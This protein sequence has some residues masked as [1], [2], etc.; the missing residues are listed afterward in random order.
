MFKRALSIIKIAVG[1]AH[2][3]YSRGAKNYAVLLR[4]LGREEEAD[5]ILDS[6]KSKQE[7]IQIENDKKVQS[8]SEE[9]DSEDKGS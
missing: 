2:P 4:K 8:S 5:S 6:I 3:R 9:K 7:L 1:V